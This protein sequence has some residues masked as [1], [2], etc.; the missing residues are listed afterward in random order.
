M[1]SILYLVTHVVLNLW[2]IICM[3]A[4][5]I[6]S[7]WGISADL[8]FFLVQKEPSAAAA[9]VWHE[10]EFLMYYYKAFLFIIQDHMTQ[11]YAL[12]NDKQDHKVII[13]RHIQL[14]VL[15][16]PRGTLHLLF[17]TT[18]I[19]STSFITA[20]RSTCYYLESCARRW[21]DVR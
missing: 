11:Q 12:I 19:T 15:I 1:K 7:T 5:N 3:W 10:T 4:A 20:L 21:H 13:H 16:I 6:L 18:L 2:W 14:H 9:V 17:L 8:G